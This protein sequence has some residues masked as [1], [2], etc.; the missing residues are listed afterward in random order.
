MGVTAGG[1]SYKFEKKNYMKHIVF[2][3]MKVLLTKFR[4]KISDFCREWTFF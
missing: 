3:R 1:F 2:E 4:H